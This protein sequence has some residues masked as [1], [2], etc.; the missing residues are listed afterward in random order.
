MLAE[1]NYDIP[2]SK[3]YTQRCCSTDVRPEWL[4]TVASSRWSD[5]LKRH[6][7]LVTYRLEDSAHKPA[8]SNVRKQHLW[9]IFAS[10]VLK[11]CTLWHVSRRSRLFLLVSFTSVTLQI[12]SA[13]EEPV[14]HY[15]KHPVYTSKTTEAAHV[16]LKWNLKRAD[17]DSELHFIYACLVHRPCSDQYS[18]LLPKLIS[19]Q[20]RRMACV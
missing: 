4:V 18:G 5:F 13:T 17:F 10:L 2:S 3:F 7:T 12:R 8:T 11:K 15:S 1:L 6:T 19:L 20:W 14:K 9:E 16:P